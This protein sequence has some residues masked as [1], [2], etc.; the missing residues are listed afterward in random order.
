MREPRDW[1]DYRDARWRAAETAWRL[2]RPAWPARVSAWAGAGLCRAL[3]GGLCGRF[4]DRLAGGLCGRARAQALRLEDGCTA[5]LAVY[6]P[7]LV[8]CVRGEAVCTAAGDAA[9][10]VLRAGDERF[11]EHGDAV[12]AVARGAAHLAVRALSGAVEPLG[13][14]WRPRTS[15]GLGGGPGRRMRGWVGGA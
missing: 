6:G 3:R 8:S 14:A 7:V 10:Y 9:D 12:V 11:F 1:R 2:C 5:R 13:D 4:G 15:D